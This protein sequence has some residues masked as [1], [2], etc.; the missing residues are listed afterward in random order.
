MAMQTPSEH[1]ADERAGKN[2]L[3]V[4]VAVSAILAIAMIAVLAYYFSWY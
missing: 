4:I 1:R 2:A 3:W